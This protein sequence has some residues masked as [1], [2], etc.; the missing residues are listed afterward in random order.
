MANSSTIDGLLSAVDTA[1]S[2]VAARDDNA[3][4]PDLVPAISAAVAAEAARDPAIQHATNAEPWYTSRVTWGAIIAALSPL[5]GL[6]LGHTVTA[7][8]Q[9]AIVE[10]GTAAGSLIGACMALYGRWVARVPIGSR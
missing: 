7:A 10:F 6:L 3:I 9:L 8:D 1:L 4:T 5:I 2:R